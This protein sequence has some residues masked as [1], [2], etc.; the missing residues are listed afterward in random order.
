MIWPN[1]TGTQFKMRQWP[2]KFSRALGCTTARVIL[3]PPVS[4]HLLMWNKNNN[5]VHFWT[6]RR[7]Y[8]VVMKTSNSAE[9][10]EVRNSERGLK[11][12]VPL[13]FWNSCS[14]DGPCQGLET[15]QAGSQHTYVQRGSV[16]TWAW[17]GAQSRPGVGKRGPGQDPALPTSLSVF[18]S[19]L[20]IRTEAAVRGLQSP[21]GINSKYDLVIWNGIELNF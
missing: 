7:S 20:W 5:S 16:Y 3:S 14:P 6:V 4:P 2:A 21:S 19:S 9:Q 8:T 10:Q 11:L 17:S 12:S 13:S 1:F 18:C 15:T